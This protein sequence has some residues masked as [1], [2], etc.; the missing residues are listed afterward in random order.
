MSP[1]L[2]ILSACVVGENARDS[3]V[4]AELEGPADPRLRAIEL[5]DFSANIPFFPVGRG[6]RV[7]RYKHEVRELEEP[8]FDDEATL[9]SRGLILVLANDSQS[10]LSQVERN[11][12]IL[13]CRSA[14]GTL[15]V[16][17]LNR[18]DA[19]EKRLSLVTRSEELIP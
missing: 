10:F 12:D 18:I 9:P 11:L 3:F 7:S 16:E 8:A 6:C 14:N 17:E 19:L 5:R 2:V 13:L 1:R 15:R 4:K